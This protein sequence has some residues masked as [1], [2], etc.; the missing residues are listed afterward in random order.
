MNSTKDTQQNELYILSTTAKEAIIDFFT[1]HPQQTELSKQDFPTK[2]NNEII[3]IP[4]NIIKI[5]KVRNNYYALYNNDT[6]LSLAKYYKKG[7]AVLRVPLK[8]KLY[9]QNIQNHKERLSEQQFNNLLKSNTA[10]A[11]K[12]SSQRLKVTTRAEQLAID[13]TKKKYN[14]T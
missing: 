11:K 13:T 14:P 12:K 9:Y 4:S 1:R 5:V 6:Q 2:Y 10:S 8:K 3:Q 7:I